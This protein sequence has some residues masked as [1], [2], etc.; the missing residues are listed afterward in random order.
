MFIYAILILL[1]AV[2]LCAVVSLANLESKLQVLLDANKDGKISLV[3][4]ENYFLSYDSNKDGQ[5]TLAEFKAGVDAV[6]PVIIGNEIQFFILL[7]L[8]ENG[9]IDKADIDN[10]FHI[11]D[12]NH[13]NFLKHSELHLII[14]FARQP[15]WKIN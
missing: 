14:A 3:E 9:H 11:V 15:W 6:D 13:D 4:T 2:T 5:V 7:D 12:L 8:D 10:A 1:P